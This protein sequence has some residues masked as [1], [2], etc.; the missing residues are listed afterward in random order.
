MN[1]LTSYIPQAAPTRPRTESPRRIAEEDECW[2]CHT[3][4]PS[5][6][7]PNYEELRE[8]HV[9]ECLERAQRNAQGGSPSSSSSPAPGPVIPPQPSHSRRQSRAEG[10][11]SSQTVPS[12]S[13]PNLATPEGRMQERERRH[14][15]VIAEALNAGAPP[16]RQVGSFPYLATEKDCID[17]AECTI[18]LEEFEVG[19]RMSRLECFCR[20]HEKCIRDWFANHPGQCPI[21]QHGAGY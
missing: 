8:A 18:C 14:A 12:A 20:F 16:I 4:L 15:A 13:I 1:P 2:V 21:H 17:D 6:T 19:V 5:R 9:L 10:S 11:R 3:E 7:L